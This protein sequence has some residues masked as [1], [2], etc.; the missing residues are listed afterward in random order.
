M[1]EKDEEVEY[2]KSHLEGERKG[3]T[4]PMASHFSL[5]AYD[6]SAVS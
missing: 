6:A 3:S 2:S 1:G 5:V 4:S